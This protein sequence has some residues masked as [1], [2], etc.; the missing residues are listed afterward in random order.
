M[1]SVDVWVVSS[2]SESSC[3]GRRNLVVIDFLKMHV[4][5]GSGSP[6]LRLT[7]MPMQSVSV[8]LTKSENK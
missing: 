2:I 1:G 8:K 6:C 3:S 7:K 5:V 4:R